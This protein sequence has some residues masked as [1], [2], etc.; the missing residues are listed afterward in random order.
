MNLINAERILIGA[1]LVVVAVAS[2]LSFCDYAFDDQLS[3]RTPLLG[4][5]TSSTPPSGRSGPMI[6]YIGVVSGYGHRAEVAAIV[7]VVFP[8]SIL[9]WGCAALV[10]RERADRRH[11]GDCERC[12]HALHS[13]PICPECGL[14]RSTRSE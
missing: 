6:S 14:A 13:A 7:G 9:A 2:H 5:A 8:I 11:R 12:G 3:Q 4:V 1:G 10:R